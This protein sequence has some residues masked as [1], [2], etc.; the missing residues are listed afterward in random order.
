MSWV[1]VGAAVLG[2]GAS[3]YG[4]NKMEDAGKDAARASEGALEESG[5]Q[6]DITREDTRIARETGND[7][8]MTLGFLLGVRQPPTAESIASLEK[9]L[10]DAQAMRQSSITAAGTVGRPLTMR[11][12]MK[13]EKNGSV[14]A[15]AA[16]ISGIDSNIES[17]KA[18]LDEAKK[19]QAIATKYPG[20]IGDFIKSQPGYQF[21]LDEGMKGVTNVLSASG[22]SQ[23]G[24]AIKEALRY[25]QDYANTKTDQYLGRVFT[26]AGYGPVAANT[27]AAVGQNLANASMTHAGNVGNISYNNANANVGAVNNAVNTGMTLLS[28][29]NMLKRQPQPVNPDLSYVPQGAINPNIRVTA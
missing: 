16:D 2:A 20:G 28:Y 14:Q 17:I 26:L 9:E 15:K 21:G 8:M 11:D 7:A 27:S 18:R 19:M 13:M 29:N 6:F 3:V 10:S 24:K 25:G 23:G 1:I 22:Q 5:R 4:A 12:A